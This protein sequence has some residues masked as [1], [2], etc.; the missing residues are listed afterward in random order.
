[1]N[2]QQLI[3]YYRNKFQVANRTLI[4][5]DKLIDSYELLLNIKDDIIANL[6]QQI[7]NQNHTIN[8]LDNE[9]KE[10]LL[11]ESDR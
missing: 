10:S 4:E 7:R 9:L 1:M 2:K 5:Q 8:I 11:K 3:D 6:K